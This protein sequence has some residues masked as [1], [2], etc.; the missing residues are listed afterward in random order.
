MV[1]M[2]II[3][4]TRAGHE[5]GHRLSSDDIRLS[6]LFTVHRAANVTIEWQA[7]KNRISD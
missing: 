7:T 2:M 3:F 5:S 4:R 6:I 1:Y